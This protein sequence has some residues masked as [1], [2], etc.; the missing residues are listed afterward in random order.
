[1]KVLGQ[2]QVKVIYK[3]Q[4]VDAPLVVVRGEGPTLFGRNWFQLIQLDWKDIRYM[5]TTI[6]TLLQ[7]HKEQ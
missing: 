4:D 2:A 5:T 6:D 3:T 7:K 1:M